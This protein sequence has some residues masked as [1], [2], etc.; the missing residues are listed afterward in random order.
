MAKV[1]YTFRAYASDESENWSLEGTPLEGVPVFGIYFI[2]EGERTHICSFTPSSRAEFLHNEFLYDCDDEAAHEQAGDLIHE[3]GGEWTS[4]FG[5]I[6]PKYNADYLSAP[7]RV[8]IDTRDIDYN[9]DEYR[10]Y[11]EAAERF[12]SPQKAH[13]TAR[14]NVAREAAYEAAREAFQGDWPN[15]PVLGGAAYERHRRKLALRA[16]EYEARYAAPNLFGA[17][18]VPLPLEMRP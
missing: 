2:L 8:V 6:D 15:I 11:V 10:E 1:A 16:A 14:Y 12:E 9:A 13:A 5:F 4:Y 17:A 18:G 3:N 7:L